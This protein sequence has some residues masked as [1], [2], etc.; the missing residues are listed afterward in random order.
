M[1]SFSEPRSKLIV[2]SW[3]P[4]LGIILC[5]DYYFHEVFGILS[6]RL[7]DIHLRLNCLMLS[8]IKIGVIC[9]SA[10]KSLSLRI[11]ERD[12]F[13]GGCNTP[14]VYFSFDHDYG[15]KQGISLRIIV[16]MFWLFFHT[17]ISLQHSS[18]SIGTIQNV[19]RNWSLVVSR[20]IEFGVCL[21]IN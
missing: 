12:S 5:E 10:L 1:S 19:S 17:R 4:I 2:I 14:G 7:D 16:S 9:F 8:L 3:Q 18:L 20:I 11:S 21:K 15:L 13:K 6:F